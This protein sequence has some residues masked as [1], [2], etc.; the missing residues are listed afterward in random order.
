MKSRNRTTGIAA[1]KIMFQKDIGRALQ[2]VK[3]FHSIRVV[4]HVVF[5]LK[6]LTQFGKK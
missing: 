6:R 1:M 2:N 4:K 3:G 5:I